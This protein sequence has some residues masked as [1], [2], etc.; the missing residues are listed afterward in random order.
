MIEPI[1]TSEECDRRNAGM[2][3]SLHR[4]MR[5]DEQERRRL[6]LALARELIP[7][8]DHSSVVRLADA[9][10]DYLDAKGYCRDDG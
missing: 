7:A 9:L 3:I 5:P 8:V 4:C 2:D 1:L 10:D 6:A